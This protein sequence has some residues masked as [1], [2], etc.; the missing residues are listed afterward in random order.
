MLTIEEYI[1]RRKKEDKLNELNMD[2]R[3]EN[4]KIC[5][6]YVFDYFH[7]YLAVGEIAEVTEVAEQ[8]IKPQNLDAEKFKEYRRQLPEYDSSLVEWLVHKIKHK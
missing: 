1:A 3:N 2:E 5:V 7:D 6:N 4:T 8:E